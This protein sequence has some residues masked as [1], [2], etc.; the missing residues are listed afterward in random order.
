MRSIYNK[1]CNIGLEISTPLKEKKRIRILNIGAAFLAL[2]TIPPIIVFFFRNELTINIVII[3]IVEFLL[4]TLVF[5]LNGIK[6]TQLAKVWISFSFLTIMFTHNNFLFPHEYAEYYYIAPAISSLFFFDK[7][8]IGFAF[9]I[10]GILLFYI[11]NVYFKIYDDKD[12]GYFHVVPFFI[13]LYVLVLYFKN[14]NQKNEEELE[15]A[16]LKLEIEKKNELAYLQLKSLKAQMTPHFIFNSLNSIQNLILKE[17]KDIAYNY[18]T[19]FSLLIRLNLKMSDKAFIYFDEELELLNQYLE[20]EQ[21][22]FK[23]NFEY[24]ITDNISNRDDIQIPSMIIQPFVE[25]SIKHGL[26]HKTSG[27]KKISIKFTLE[28]KKMSCTIIDNGIGIENSKK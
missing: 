18:L 2:N 9:L 3:F 14:E 26:M 10:I 27:F 1:I 22:R 4:Y 8:K 15:K 12:F 13:G 24:K 7:T 28:G 23:E 6:R 19:K 25:N 11:P 21:L 17:Q 5:V 20:L 16:Y